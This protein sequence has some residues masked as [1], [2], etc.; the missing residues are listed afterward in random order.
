MAGILLEE[1]SPF[2]NIIAVVEDD[3]RVI[4]FYLHFLDTPED[5]PQRMKVCWVRNRQKAPARLDQAV[6][7]RGEPPLMPAAHCVHPGAGQPLDAEALHIV[8]FEE[9]DAGA[10]LEQENILAIIPSW[11]GLEDFSG[12]ARDCVGE[13]PFAWELS[14]ENV[15]LERIRAAHEFWRLWDDEDFWSRWRDERIDAIER[16]LGPHTKYYAID[17]DEFPP[18]AMLRF[19]LPDRYVL[20]TVGVSLFS[21]PGVERYFENPSPYRRIE[22][23]AVVDRGC[24]DVELARF[25][26]YISAQARY[27][28]SQFAPLGIGHTMP[29]DSTPQSC[30]GDRFDYVAFTNSLPGTPAIELPAFRG[31]PVNVLWLFPITNAERGFAENNTTVELIQR[32]QQAGNS[33]LIRNRHPLKF[34]NK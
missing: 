25:E 24:P 29:C 34:G 22:L 31:D 1:P 6:M 26:Q 27:P 4:Y 3:D 30:G 12:Y 28:W 16:V 32:L 21:Q 13:G 11:S 7:E 17:G 9:C 10:L 18:R 20:V 2:G 23:A 33:I 5:D 15:L 8:W 19:D 14:P